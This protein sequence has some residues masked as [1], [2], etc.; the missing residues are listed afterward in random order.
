MQISEFFRLEHLKCVL[1]VGVHE[2]EQVGEYDS[3]CFDRQNS[4]IWVEALAK[5][6]DMTNPKRMPL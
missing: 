2:A 6:L 5:S 1:K 4:V 3:N